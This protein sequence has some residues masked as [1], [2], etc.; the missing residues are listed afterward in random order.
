MNTVFHEPLG[1]AD[2][3]SSCTGRARKVTELYLKYVW[4]SGQ[5]AT[6][7][8]TPTVPHYHLEN[9]ALKRLTLDT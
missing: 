3:Q 2:I 8:T 9:A 7:L 5:I 4:I 6:A 1:S